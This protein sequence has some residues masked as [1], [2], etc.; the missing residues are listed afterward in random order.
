MIA[1]IF[2][3][4]HICTELLFLFDMYVYI[5]FMEVYYLCVLWKVLHGL[6]TAMIFFTK[7]REARRLWLYAFCTCC[8]YCCG[9]NHNNN[10]N[11][12]GLYDISETEYDYQIRNILQVSTSTA[13]PL[14]SARTYFS[15]FSLSRKSQGSGGRSSQSDG[16]SSSN[17]HLHL[18]Q[19][20]LEGSSPS[21]SNPSGRSDIEI[22][23][24]RML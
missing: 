11:L 4:P 12:E 22:S 10:D 1:I 3:L 20:G 2:W 16:F 6:V 8:C 7:S 19:H 13:T 18:Q 14:T 9:N 5:E 21:I 24:H 23:Y 17:N 15:S